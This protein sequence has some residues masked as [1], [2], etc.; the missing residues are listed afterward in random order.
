MDFKELLTDSSK[1]LIIKVT[2]FV[3]ENPKYFDEVYNLALAEI[4]KFSPR[5]ARIIEYFYVAAPEEV[6]SYIPDIIRKLPKIKSE[7]VRRGLCKIFTTHDLKS[8][9]EE[10]LGLLVNTCFEFLN[11]SKEAIAV[12]CYSMI[13]I[14]K[15]IEFEPDLQSEYILSLENQLPFFSKG[16]KNRVRKMTIVNPLKQ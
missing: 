13:I 9:D 14:E 12:K 3:I 1:D 5:A 11:S 4:P 7:G 6:E 15:V 8:I 16:L 2:K 10:L